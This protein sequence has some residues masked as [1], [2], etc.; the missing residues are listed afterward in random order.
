MTRASHFDRHGRRSGIRPFP[1]A[2]PAFANARTSRI[3]CH[4]PESASFIGGSIFCDPTAVRVAIGSMG[5]SERQIK[6]PKVN[7][8]AF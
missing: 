6:F 5:F 3:F 8:I 2:G 7:F 1:M 4:I